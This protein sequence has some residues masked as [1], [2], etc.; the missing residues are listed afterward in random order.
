MSGAD[1]LSGGWD[2]IFNYPRG[3]RPNAFTATLRDAGG[4]LTGETTEPSQDQCDRNA[5]LHAW[6]E[7]RRD[8]TAVMFVK[9]YDD[10]KRAHYA[11]HYDGSVT[12]DGNEING[13]WNIPGVWS[14]TFIMVRKAGKTEEAE[15]KIAETIR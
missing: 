11:V 1:D 8:G 15:Q 9:S 14:G 7:G 2:G 10:P 12:P 6:L 3:Y 5:V 4:F 13:R